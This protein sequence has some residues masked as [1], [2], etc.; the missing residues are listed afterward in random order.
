MPSILV[1]LCCL[2]RQERLGCWHKLFA[3]S[4]P[5]D[6]PK[7]R[8]TFFRQCGQVPWMRAMECEVAGT[9]K[10]TRFGRICFSA[11]R[12]GCRDRIPPTSRLIGLAP[13]EKRCSAEANHR[14]Y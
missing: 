13:S 12:H 7:R 1:Q 5:L 11:L 9:E 4:K 10:A 3:S 14:F 2:R 6:G 8:L